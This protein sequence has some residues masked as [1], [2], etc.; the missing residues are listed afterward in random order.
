[1]K[2]KETRRQIDLLSNVKTIQPERIKMLLNDLNRYAVDYN[3]LMEECENDQPEIE[4]LFILLGN[5]DP[6]MYQASLLFC[7]VFGI[8]L[9]KIEEKIDFNSEVP[10]FIRVKKNDSVLKQLL[11]ELKDHNGKSRR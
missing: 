9:Y 4:I 8:I 6:A 1:M 3:T 11:K 7:Q 2:K 10:D 5:N